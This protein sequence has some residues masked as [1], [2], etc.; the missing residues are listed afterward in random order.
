MNARLEPIIA[1][2][3]LEFGRHC[4]QDGDTTWRFEVLTS[5]GRSHVVTMYLKESSADG[6]D[7]SRL[8]AIA[9]IG[10]VRTGISWE[11]LLRKNAELDVGTIAIED[12][13]TQEHVRLPFVV[14]RATHLVATVDYAEVW[15]LVS[16]TGE[17]ADQL[18]DTL[19]SRDFL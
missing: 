5:A 17:Y 10:P 12:I 18:E 9:P 11:R 3:R 14:F 2:L 8:V 13:W 16:K 4:Q 7:L 19:F 1:Q 15:E 6:K